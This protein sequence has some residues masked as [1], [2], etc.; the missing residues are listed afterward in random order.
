LKKFLAK[1]KLRGY[2]DVIL[3]TKETKKDKPSYQELKT[4]N[5]LAHAK[6]LVSCESDLCFGIIENSKSEK[7]PDGDA[8]L[9]WLNLSEKF[10]PKTKMNIIKLKK[11]FIECKLNS[12]NK[13][14][15]EWLMNLENLKW[16][17]KGIGHEVSNEDM[18]VHIL[19]NLP[20]EYENTI[21][22]MEI[23]LEN[24][25]LNLNKMRERLRNKFTRFDAQEKKDDSDTALV[26]KNG[27]KPIYKKQCYNNGE[28]GHTGYDCPKREQEKNSK[29]AEEKEER[30][31]VYKCHLFGDPSHKKC[32]CPFHYWNRKKER[33]NVSTE[34]KIVLMGGTEDLEN[35]NLWICDTGASCHMTG[36]LEGL[37]NIKNIDQKVISGD[38]RNL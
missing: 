37:F 30:K 18:M 28:I 31:W 16:K 38:G 33:V 24:G 2:K 8:A 9:A 11:E 5:D 22:I 14:L 35:K 1:L 27:L 19:H 26:A 25:K 10:E 6:L 3:G 4:L 21:E 13:D 32:N 20:K 15:I 17:Q 34:N 23:E 29:N 36:S 12:F 7:F